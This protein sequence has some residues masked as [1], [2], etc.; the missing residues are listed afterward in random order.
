MSDDNLMGQVIQ[1]DEGPDPRPSWRDGSWDGGRDAERHAGCRSRP[2]RLG[3]GVPS[4]IKTAQQ[5]TMAMA[6]DV[7]LRIIIHKD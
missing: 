3:K 1:I 7:H 5:H 4:A 6:P 2:A